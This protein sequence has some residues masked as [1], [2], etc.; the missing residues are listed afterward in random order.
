MQRVVD[1]VVF[2]AA[3]ELCSMLP[4]GPYSLA[5]MRSSWDG[6]AA[7]LRR[8]VRIAAIYQAESARSPDML[9]YLAEFA[10]AGAKLRVTRRVS[11]RTMI[12]DAT[13]AVIAVE[14]DTLRLPY[15]LVRE[16]A[17]VRNIRAEFTALWRRAHA[18]GVGAGNVPH[19][20]RAAGG[21]RS[22][23]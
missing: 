2:G 16:H 10:D 23:Q 14:P 11:H 22:R 9:R 6:D 8:G 7:L 12:A 5:V 13:A 19:H 17:L 21:S 1:T 3:T 20:I 18:V 15:L 4:A